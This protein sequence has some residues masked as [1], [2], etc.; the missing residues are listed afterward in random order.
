[1]LLPIVIFSDCISSRYTVINFSHIVRRAQKV[2]KVFL[3]IPPSFLWHL[4][5]HWRPGF[6]PRV[7]K[8]AWRRER[9]PPPVFWP[10]EKSHTQLSDFHLQNCKVCILNLGTRTERVLFFAL[11]FCVTFVVT[12]VCY[13][14]G[15]GPLLRLP[16]WCTRALHPALCKRSLRPRWTGTGAVWHCSIGQHFWKAKRR[17][18]LNTKR[19]KW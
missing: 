18:W 12:V 16:V 5:V 15:H 9:L 11:S 17:Q 4:S 1:M 2:D 13:P 3:S 6:N 7:G 8:I 19:L 10:G 14:R